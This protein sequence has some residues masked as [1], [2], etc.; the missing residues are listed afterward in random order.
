MDSD[1]EIQ[2]ALLHITEEGE[3]LL[4]DVEKFILQK[5]KNG[6]EV[7]SHSRNAD[8]ISIIFKRNKKETIV[9]KLMN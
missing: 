3:L 6:W 7:I 1:L 2:V 4:S 8:E 9:K 5:Y